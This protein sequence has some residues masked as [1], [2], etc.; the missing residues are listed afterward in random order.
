MPCLPP[1]HACLVV[2]ME[3]K[4][5]E[6]CRRI[7]STA[8]KR[9]MGGSRRTSFE[10]TRNGPRGEGRGFPSDRANVDVVIVFFLALCPFW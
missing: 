4:L 2:R 3:K 10:G 8:Q 1:F 6:V 5:I 7:N 9:E